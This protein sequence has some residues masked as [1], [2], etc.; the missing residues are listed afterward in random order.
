WGNACLLALIECVVGH[1]LK[2]DQGPIGHVMASL[3]HELPLGAELHQAGHYKGNSR[4]LPLGRLCRFDTGFLRF[5]LATIC[6]NCALGRYRFSLRNDRKVAGHSAASQV[7]RPAN[8]AINCATLMGS[9]NSR[10]ILMT[11]SPAA[12]SGSVGCISSLRS[13]D[14]V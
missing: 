10:A 1:L 11:A 4:Q 2:H 7:P 8:E 14:R 5:G 9:E 3:I 12:R 13:P 6:K